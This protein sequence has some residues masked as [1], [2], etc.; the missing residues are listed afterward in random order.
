MIEIFHKHAIFLGGLIVKK[1][2]EE[3]KGPRGKKKWRN[4]KPKTL[5]YHRIQVVEKC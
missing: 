1:N 3:R 5:T 4:V 2:G